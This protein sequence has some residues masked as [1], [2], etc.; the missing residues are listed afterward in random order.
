M[1]TV[2]RHEDWW[3]SADE[4]YSDTSDDTSDPATASAT[5]AIDVSLA[6]SI[7]P[8]PISGSIVF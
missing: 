2:L 8:V 1:E 6:S 5:A 7:S 3:L 4:N